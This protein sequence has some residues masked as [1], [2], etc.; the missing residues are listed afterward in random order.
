[1]PGVFGYYEELNPALTPQ[2]PLTASQLIQYENPAPQFDPTASPFP[3]AGGLT[4]QLQQYGLDD[5]SNHNLQST[6]GIGG[7]SS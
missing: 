2:P 7:S 6:G 4:P 5:I 3:S 1:M